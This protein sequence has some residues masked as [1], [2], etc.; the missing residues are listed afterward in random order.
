[1]SGLC[2]G[3]LGD[4]SRTSSLTKHGFIAGL[5]PVNFITLA[6]PHLGVRGRRQVRNPDLDLCVFCFVSSIIFADFVAN[7]KGLMCFLFFFCRLY[8]MIATC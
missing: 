2:N 8:L 5:E 4:A 1:M 3:E 6:S 7:C